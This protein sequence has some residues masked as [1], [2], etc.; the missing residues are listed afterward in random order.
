M[1]PDPSPEKIADLFARL[2]NE[3]PEAVDRELE[4]LAAADPDL[5]REITSLLEADRIAGEFLG[6]LD[7]Q[8][9]TRL[10]EDDEANSTPRR[11][12]P[13]RLLQEIGRGGMGAVYLAER[14]EGGFAQRAAVKIVKRGMDSDAIVARFLRER[15]ILASLEH[16]GIGRLLD[17]GLADDGRPY[18]AMEYV[19]GESLLTWCQ[20]RRLSL[21]DRLRLFER[22]TRSVQYAHARLV[23]H[24]DLKPANILVTETGQPKLLDFGIAKLLDGPDDVTAL[25]AGGRHLMTLRYAAP[26]QVRGELVTVAT[27]VYALGLLLYELLTG[28]HPNPGVGLTQRQI[29]EAIC[30]AVPMP[31]SA[32]ISTD[33]GTA[34]AETLGLRPEALRRQLRGDLDT[35]VLEA[36]AKEPERRYASAQALADDVSAF[37]Q[38]LPIEARVPSRLYRLQRFVGRHRGAV[39]AAVAVGL[40]LIVGATLA[41]W[42][43]RVAKQERDRA[44][45]EA[46]RAQQVQAFLTGLFEASDPEESQGEEVT[47]RELLDRGVDRIDQ[48]LAD[49]PEAQAE[50]SIVLG[51]VNLSLGRYDQA[52][53]LFE[54]GLAL[55]QAGPAAD[56][57]RRARVLRNLGEAR[58]ARGEYE[59]A[60]LLLRE[61]VRLRQE[62][63]GE[64]SVEAAESL[65]ALGVNLHYDGDLDQAGAL[66]RQAYSIYRER[67]GEG[68]PASLN[69]LHNLANL[70][71]DQG[72]Y[73]E[74]I[75][76][77]QRILEL[78]LPIYGEVHTE[79][80]TNLSSLAAAYRIRGFYTEAFEMAQRAVAVKTQLYGE[81]HPSVTTTWNNLGVIL[82]SYGHYREAEP[83]FRRVLEGDRR[84]LPPNHRYLAYS[85]DNLASV[86]AEQGRTDEA[87]RLLD[88]AESVYERNDDLESASFG[89]HLEVRSRT[90]EVAGRRQEAAEL[91]DRGLV[92]L[93]RERGDEHPRTLSALA[94]RARLIGTEPALARAK[95]QNVLERQRRILPAGH[96]DIAI[97]LIELAK[98]ESNL[99]EFELS[100]KAAE[101]ALALRRDLFPEDHWMV[102][103]GEALVAAVECQSSADR[104]STKTSPAMAY[105][106]ALATVESGLG[107]DH[108]T[109][110]DLEVLGQACR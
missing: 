87:L 89:T 106:R 103:E 56:P 39:L 44:R 37:L 43:G 88:E 45:L 13:Y 107:A 65:D 95:L 19:E 30:S 92:I 29:E 76:L 6:P 101:E 86:V 82:R 100:R 14:A 42:Q 71:K 74:S 94:A 7:P 8:L 25:T 81:E 16:P 66:Y 91:L 96:P 64:S 72:S 20:E 33:E 34:M 61:S 78:S 57:I 27:D 48:D 69:T 32:A 51:K 110:Q 109:A 68:D 4:D 47:A 102:A 38:G 26:E 75:E 2:Q 15:K 80:A 97:T 49:Q 18:F 22:V 21:A 35:I 52:V 10:L 24:R 54:R 85:L 98:I 60:T 93:R 77:H 31:P 90:L 79:I 12:G 83:I 11:A 108:P 84:S 67:L 104:Q 46:G 53:E 50:L 41:L 3:A 105:S 36:L 99:G 28:R 5:H 17:G 9:S 23:V 55:S 59:E 70:V 1:R 73:D 62:L 40:A 58:S 63:F